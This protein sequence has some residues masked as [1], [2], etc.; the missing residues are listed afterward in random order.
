MRWQTAEKVGVG[1]EWEV[2][3][4]RGS[5]LSALWG[6]RPWGTQLY[7]EHKVYLS[8]LV[9]DEGNGWYAHALGPE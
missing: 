1:R 6:P 7:G 3:E 2:W 9:G 4:G 8:N 5:A